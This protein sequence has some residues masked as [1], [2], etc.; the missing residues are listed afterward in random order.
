MFNIPEDFRKATIIRGGEAGRVWLEQLPSVIEQLCKQWQLTLAGAPMN[1]YLG[2]VFPVKRGDEELI[3]KLSWRDASN[4]HE[5]LALKT[6][7]G[8]GAVQLLDE[9]PEDDALLLERLDA[10]RSLDTVDVD[11]AVEVAG[12]LYERLAVPSPSGIPI[13]SD[14]ALK[15]ASTLTERWEHQGRPFSK[16]WL[17]KAQGLALELAKPERE[18]L[19][20]YDLH[21]GNVLAGTRELWLVIDPKVIAGD[22]EFGIAQLLWCRFDIGE[23]PAIKTRFEVLIDLAELDR[24]KARAWTFVRCIDYWLWGL[25]VGLTEDP[26]RC[27]TIADW[28]S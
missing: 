7:N 11:A 5:A 24:S 18:L 4:E 27:K 1:G 15:L 8:N 10:Q 14:V 28:L 12:K 22:K 23:L 16:A 2:L 13:Q 3:L 20:N 19:I 26:I 21:Y 9:A 25:S 17:D 6:W